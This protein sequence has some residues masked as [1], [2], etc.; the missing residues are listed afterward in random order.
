V[1]AASERPVKER[2][3]LQMLQ[4]LLADRFKLKVHTESREVP[5]YALVLARGGSK[6]HQVSV[7]ELASK[8]GQTV[9]G[10]KS[11]DGHAVDVAEFARWLKV[12]IGRPVIDRTGLVGKYDVKIE[13]T[14]DDT[15][16][17]AD[18]TDASVFV[19]LQALGLRLEAI[20]G[21]VKVLVVDHAEKPVIE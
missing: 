14:L 21:A 2:E 4:A 20:R 16:P 19:G 17:G 1:E 9:I 5:E 15:A 10:S 3:R 11:F 7:A 8:P 18:Q 6:L 13:F 12:E